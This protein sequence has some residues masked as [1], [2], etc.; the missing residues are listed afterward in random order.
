MQMDDRTQNHNHAPTD[1][2]ALLAD[3]ETALKGVTKLL[4]A[5]R[6]Y[7][8]GHPAL[9]D[10]TRD[11]RQTFL[12][13]FEGRAN[14]ILQVRRDGFLFEEKPVSSDNPMLQKLAGVLFARRVQRLM[15]LPDINCRDLWNTVQALTIDAAE[16]QRRGGLQ[17]ELQRAKVS[18]LWF[19]VVDLASVLS[20][21]EQLENEKAALYGQSGGDA[22][23]EQFLNDLG[24][25]AQP[26]SDRESIVT[27][28]ETEKITLEGLLTEIQHCASDRKIAE[29]FPQL[30]PLV[31]SNLQPASSPL[32]WHALNLTA[33]NTQD[34]RF[35][36]I[37]RDCARQTLTQLGTND[38]LTYFLQLLTDRNLIEEQRLRGCRTAAL[39]GEPMTQL[40]LSRLV[41]EGDLTQRKI[42]IDVLIRQGSAVLT[43]VSP[44]LQDGRWQVV[45]NAANVLGEI[46]DPNTIELLKPLLQHQDLRV[47]REAI[48]GL[49][50]IG[51]NQVVSILLRTLQQDDAE[52]RRQAMLSL[53][54]MKNTTAV[55]ALV[56]YIQ[57]ADPRVKM[58]EEKKDAIRAL[59][60][61]GAAE[62]LPPLI[63]LANTRKFFFRARHNELRAAAL[64]AIGDIGGAEAVS[65]LEKF[66][67][68][69]AAVIA[70]AATS[71]LRQ[72]RKASRR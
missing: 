67:A 36:A 3:I 58:V 19:N 52:L 68:D 32:V 62:G 50:R 43:V 21:K 42:L 47:K 10:V 29:L 13:L 5:I 4:G 70:K 23:D 56:Q 64:S 46:R 12:P 11:A 6:F 31:R 34:S 53:G 61:I 45:R 40:L 1:H 37:R 18:T 65:T 30:P 48:R 49:T 16:L 41:D 9:K 15:I 14:L 72:A 27:Q 35:S 22:D 7:P 25:E 51:G 38:I 54:S 24:G 69:G 55:P 28:P 26:E 57:L 71:A 17:E 2:K 59:G 8:A 33:E 66:A 39:F 60:E 20:R 44:L 63:A